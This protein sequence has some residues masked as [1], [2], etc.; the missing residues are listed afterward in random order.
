MYYF[1]I[2]IRLIAAIMLFWAL[3]D[4]PYG[5]Y[6][7]LRWVVFMVMGIMAFT[8]YKQEKEPWAW[9]FTFA[10]IL[11]NPLFPIHLSRNIWAFLDIFASIF[12][13]IS[14]FFVGVNRKQGQE[15]A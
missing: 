2:F 1:L 3:S 8:A 7:L 11:F 5:Y 15:N 4:N 12:I 14:L 13:F 10:A 6:T 9:S